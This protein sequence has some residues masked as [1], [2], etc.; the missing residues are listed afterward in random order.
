VLAELAGIA[1]FLKALTGIYESTQ[2]S[3]IEKLF[4][5]ANEA[6]LL[7]SMLLVLALPYGFEM[8]ILAMKGVLSSPPSG[9]G[10]TS[11]RTRQHLPPDPATPPSGPGNTSPGPGRRRRRRRPHGTGPKNR[12]NGKRRIR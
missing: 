1:W 11:L 4:K 10:N 7:L 12:G 9:P 6:A 8:Q 2:P 3:P 5:S